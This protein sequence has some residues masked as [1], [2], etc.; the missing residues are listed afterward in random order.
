[1]NVD[2]RPTFNCLSIFVTN[3]MEKTLCRIHTY[4]EQDGAE[5]I[6]N[7]KAE[8]KNME[9]WQKR[10]IEERNELRAK[11]EKLSDFVG[12]RDSLYKLPNKDIE[13]LGRQHESM[14][15]YISILNERIGRFTG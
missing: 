12:D 9:D 5:K 4:Q 11:L 15:E 3:Q 2:T 13:L 10:V 6:I 1:V 14:T 7:P 8:E